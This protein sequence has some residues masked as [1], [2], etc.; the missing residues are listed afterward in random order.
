MFIL[1]KFHTGTM[2]TQKLALNIFNF[3][4]FQNPRFYKTHNNVL[5][6]VSWPNK[7]IASFEIYLNFRRI[8][9]FKLLI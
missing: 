6:W 7:M 4:K 5:N 1:A 9:G 8:F 3:Y 2:L